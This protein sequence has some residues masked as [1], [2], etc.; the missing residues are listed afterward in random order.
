MRRSLKP[1][2]LA[3]GGASLALAF[4]C[5]VAGV[6]QGPSALVFGATAV[7]GA[8]V[9]RAASGGCWAACNAGWMCN[10]DSGRCEPISR[11]AQPRLVRRPDPATNAADA[12][13]DAGA[14]P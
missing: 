7:A 2:W 12:G 5:R 6:P 14:V 4:A 10:P 11:E 13:A 8:A 1:G 3:I 9:Y